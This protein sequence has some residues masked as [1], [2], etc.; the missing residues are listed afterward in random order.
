MERDE[1]RLK[2]PKYSEKGKPD[3]QPMQEY[4][5]FVHGGV[6]GS[7]ALPPKEQSARGIKKSEPSKSGI[8]FSSKDDSEA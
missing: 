6:G 7:K 2:Y 1:K 4:E 5:F 8:F 3:P